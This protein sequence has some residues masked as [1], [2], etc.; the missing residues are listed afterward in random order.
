MVK[1]RLPNK[2]PCP[3]LSFH[4]PPKTHILT[5]SP[6]VPGRPWLTVSLG[7]YFGFI[8]GAR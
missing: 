7:T 3:H 1:S 2:T 6:W 4:W 8:L 5:G